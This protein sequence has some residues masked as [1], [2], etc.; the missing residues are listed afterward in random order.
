MDLGQEVART[1]HPPTGKGFSAGER[2]RAGE[3]GCIGR[4]G[5]ENRGRK[6]RGEPMV[7]GRRR[8]GTSPVSGVGIGA[9]RVLGCSLVRCNF[10]T[11]TD[12]RFA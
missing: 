4:K 5:L 6:V 11:E 10:R 2:G 1:H 12:I 9:W 8:G 3:G 7:G